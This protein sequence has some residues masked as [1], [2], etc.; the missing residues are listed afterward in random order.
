MSEAE[1]WKCT[2]A[3]LSARV[4]AEQ[5]KRR[6]VWEIERFGAWLALSPHLK[7]HAK[8]QDVARFAWETPHRVEID[9]QT[10]DAAEERMNRLLAHINE[11]NAS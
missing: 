6:E 11:Q 5:Q 9:T 10:W 2:P 8:I 4:K 7:K 3:Y 1:M